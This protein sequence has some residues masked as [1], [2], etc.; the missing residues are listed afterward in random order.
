ML[1]GDFKAAFQSASV[2][3]DLLTGAFRPSAEW[4]ARVVLEG[5]GVQHT[6]TK[7]A[8][9]RKPSQL[10][11]SVCQNLPVVR[12]ETLRGAGSSFRA[13]TAPTASHLRN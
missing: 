11:P 4:N 2:S 8:L 9:E 10:P 1:N 6:W 3:F 5:D 12:T 7:R 13:T